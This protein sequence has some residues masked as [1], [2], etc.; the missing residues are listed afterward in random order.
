MGL[1]RSNLLTFLFNLIAP[2]YRYLTSNK[3]WEENA[4]YLIKI[5][6]SP[7]ARSFLDLGTGPGYIAHA[8]SQMN[9]VR[10]VGLD[11]AYS[12]LKM[13]SSQH[14]HGVSYILGDSCYSPFRD[15][16]FDVITARSFLWLVKS[17][18]K[19]LTEVRRVLREEGRLILV[20]PLSDA[21]LPTILRKTK[22]FKVCIAHF[23]WFMMSRLLGCYRE[24]T[25][26]SMLTESGFSIC[27]CEKEFSELAL[28]LVGEKSTHF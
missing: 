10:V 11:C 21:R 15:N 6:C 7:S 14:N 8:L 22:S 13:A 19:T 26:K 2:L 5:A 23:G 12:M 24:E 16:T 25:L 18:R 17:P 27:H 28:I 3:A 1:S 9:G 20:E 4:R